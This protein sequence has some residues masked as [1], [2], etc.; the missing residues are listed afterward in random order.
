MTERESRYSDKRLG[1][2]GEVVAINNSEGVREYFAI[3]INIKKMSDKLFLHTL[4]K[5]PVF[6]HKE[7][8]KRAK[9][10]DKERRENARK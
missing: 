10:T 1:R 5:L 4:D 9:S 8:V 2:I 7:K 6:T 3:V